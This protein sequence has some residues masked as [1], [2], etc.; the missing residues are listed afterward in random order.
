MLQMY[1]VLRIFNTFLAYEEC[2]ENSVCLYVCP[3][4]DRTIV[5][6]VRLTRTF[7]KAMRFIVEC[8]LRKMKYVTFSHK[9]TQDFCYIMLYMEKIDCS[10]F[11]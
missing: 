8:L 10:A 11:Y 4:N 7:K 5:N 6:I 2:F 3:S 1:A 9:D